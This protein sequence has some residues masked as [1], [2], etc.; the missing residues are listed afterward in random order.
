[1]NDS[2]Y[3]TFNKWEKSANKIGQN[4]L[5]NK[6]QTYW[7]ELYFDVILVKSENVLYS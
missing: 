2:L 7:I 5:M 1:M 3:D 4:Y 6:I